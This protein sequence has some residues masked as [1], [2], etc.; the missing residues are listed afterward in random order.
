MGP[1]AVILVF[2]M[3]SFKPA[4]SLLFHFIKRLFSSSLLS[5]IWLVSSAF[6]RLLIFF[7]AILIPARASSCLAF[8]MMYS[9]YKLNK[10][11][12]NIQ[13]WRTRFLIWNPSVV[14]YPVLIVASWPT[15]RFLKR[16]VR[17]ELKRIKEKAVTP[18][19][20][21]L[22]WKIPW[23]EEPGGLQSM[24]SRR[25]GQDWA[26]SRSLFTFM[27]WRRK[28]QPTPVFLP[29]ESQGQGSLVGCHLWGHT[30]L[31]MTEVT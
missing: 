24:G 4:F 5:A 11:G 23:T 10:Q 21:T 9:A 8:H 28:G 2:W 22:A 18:H 17:W 19:S 6:L 25:V 15:Y 26:T 1:D 30:E 7:P 14:P 31:D 13:P 20:S 16:Q 29:G 27:L 12:D 3:L